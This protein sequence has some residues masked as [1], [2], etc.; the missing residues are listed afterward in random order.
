MVKQ[1]DMIPEG[2]EFF[3]KAFE[4]DL[5]KPQFDNLKSWTSGILEGLS[6]VYEIGEKFSSKHITSLTRFMNESPWNHKELNHQRIS[7]TTKILTSRYHKYYP[8]IIDDTVNKKYGDLLKGIGHFYSNTEKRVITGQSIVTS[9]LYT[10]QSD[11]PLFVDLYL[12]QEDL[13]DGEEFRSKID[14]AKDHIKKA[15]HLPSRQGVVIT[16]SW[17]S[18]LPIIK[19]TIQQAFEGIFALKSNRIV[20]FKG[21]KHQVWDL[22]KLQETNFELV[23]VEEKEYRVWTSKVTTP[24]I[25]REDG[26]KPKKL[27]LLISQ[28]KLANG[29]W[30]DYAYLLATDMSM[31]KWTILFLY[32]KRWKIESFYKFAKNAFDFSG[33]QL[34]SYQGIIRYFLLLFFAYSY[35]TLTRFPHFLYWGESRSLYKAFENSKEERVENMVTW[36]YN[37]TKKGVDLHQ[38]KLKLGFL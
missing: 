33:S 37:E 7:W 38:I 9:H 27:R 13:A 26:K 14:I 16:D 5:S 36:V 11:I 6:S 20:N 25:T 12:K 18:G 3:L 32:R 29:K 21:K 4:E 19:E 30:S 34:H 1:I 35:L 10:A 28:L 22:A 17:Y 15:P 24:G 23:T 31:G 8:I 2:L